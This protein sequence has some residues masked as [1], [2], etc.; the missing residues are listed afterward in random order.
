MPAPH[1]VPLPSLV[2]REELLPTWPG[3]QGHGA[4]CWHKQAIRQMA[5]NRQ[6]ASEDLAATQTAATRRH[7]CNTM[8]GALSLQHSLL[9]ALLQ[10][11]EL[12]SP[13]Q[14][15]GVEVQD[16]VD[17]TAPTLECDIGASPTN[18]PCDETPRTP[19][20]PTPRQLSISACR[21]RLAMRLPETSQLHTTMTIAMPY[22]KIA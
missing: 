16:T 6:H 2:M 1:P 17:F 4:G 13:L 8:R 21:F 12:L 18:V 3:L 9:R 14:H 5:K 7:A 11:V 20:H 10:G 15:Q 19:S 22:R